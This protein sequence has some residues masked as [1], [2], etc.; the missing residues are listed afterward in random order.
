MT[1]RGRVRD[2]DRV[3]DTEHLVEVWQRI[4]APSGVSW[5][6]FE[7]GTCVML[8]EPDGELAGQAVEIL[9]QYGPVRAGGPA[10]DFG[11]RALKD[12]TGWLVTGHHPDVVTYVGSEEPADPSNLAVGLHGRS[13]RHRD[14][15]DLQVVH[16]ED[17]R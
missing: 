6:L 14:G 17:T 11:T 4:L 8:K 9:R 7:N 15:T 1:V 10:G 3:D 12:G 16:V 13:K 2:H 5:V